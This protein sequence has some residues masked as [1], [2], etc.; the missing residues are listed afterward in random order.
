MLHHAGQG[1]NDPGTRLVGSS[2]TTAAVASS[3]YQ[4]HSQL[5]A[6]AGSLRRDARR[7][8]RRCASGGSGASGATLCAADTVDSA[9]LVL[10]T[11]PPF[12][13]A[14]A[15]TASARDSRF[16]QVS[17]AKAAQ[18]DCHTCV[19]HAIA[20]AAEAAVASV[21]QVDASTVSVSEQVGNRQASSRMDWQ[22]QAAQG[23]AT[24]WHVT[25]E[26]GPSSCRAACCCCKP[27]CNPPANN[28]QTPC[29]ICT[30]A[31]Q[32]SPAA[33]A[34]VAGPCKQAWRP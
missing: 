8:V 16:K 30:T 25:I 13:D 11:S 24:E 15:S 9:A 1:L 12:Y 14:S 34:P 18:G 29:R 5:T 27:T 22:D 32:H 33:C 17:S 31:R 23:Q 4:R 26:A 6:R 7:G 19:A 3:T 28:V 2:T 10:A 21:M 20:A